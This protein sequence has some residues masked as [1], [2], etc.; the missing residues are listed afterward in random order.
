MIHLVRGNCFDKK[1]V[2]HNLFTL[3]KTTHAHNC[4]RRLGERRAF[5]RSPMGLITKQGNTNF[6]YSMQ[7]LYVA[8]GDSVT[9]AVGVLP[10]AIALLLNCSENAAP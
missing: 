3:C 5:T 9:N 2:M 7:C 6:Q 1:A 8:V 4:A 10:I